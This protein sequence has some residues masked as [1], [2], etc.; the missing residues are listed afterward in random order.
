MPTMV[1]IDEAADY[2]DRNVGIILSQ[3]RKYNVG[4]VLAHQYMGQLEAKLQDAIAANTSIKFAGGVSTKDARVLAPMMGCAP[5]LIETQSKG[6]FA[7]FVRGVTKS[8]IPLKFPLGHMEGLPQMSAREFNELRA[9]MRKKYAVHYSELEAIKPLIKY[10]MEN[11]FKMD[12]PL[13]VEMGA[14]KNWFEAH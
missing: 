10:E 11:A 13:E 6:S 8:A 2:F 3:A 1:Y 4:M 5:E 12:V 9:L 14:G 7:A